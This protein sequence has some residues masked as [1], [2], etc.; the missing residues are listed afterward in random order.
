MTD[1]AQAQELKYR[2]TP[3]MGEISG[4]GGGYEENCQKML[5]GGMLW[6]DGH[7]EPDLKGHTYKNIFGIFDADSDDAKELERVVIA[8]TDDCT[9]AMIQSVMQRL[10]WIA[11]NGGWEAY[12]EHMIQYQKDKGNIY[13]PVL[14]DAGKVTCNGEVLDLCLDIRNHS[15]TGFAWGYAGSGPAQ[16]ALAIMVNEYGRDLDEHPVHYQLFKNSVITVLPQGK[17]WTVT[18]K[19]I[20]EAIERI[21]EKS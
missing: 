15:P 5:N 12:V 18:S 11:H 4:F 21:R 7:K 1:A 14:D 13:E 2:H 10:F 6:L 17:D 16:L 20:R 8:A 19:D 9:G 3:E